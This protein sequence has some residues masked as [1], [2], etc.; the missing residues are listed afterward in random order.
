MQQGRRTNDRR[1][2]VLYSAHQAEN[3]STS[4]ASRRGGR[5]ASRS[6]V[7]ANGIRLA[8]ASTDS[9]SLVLTGSCPPE[10]HAAGHWQYLSVGDHSMCRAL[11]CRHLGAPVNTSHDCSPAT[12]GSPRQF[13]QLVHGRHVNRHCWHRLNDLPIASISPMTTLEGIT[14][15]GGLSPS[16]VFWQASTYS[17]HWLTGPVQSSTQG[18]ANVSP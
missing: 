17:H 14:D 18:S 7:S 9:R 1:R 11:R 2:R 13:R 5:K 10:I 4:A 15:S 3:E 8:C 16:S 12:L 6:P